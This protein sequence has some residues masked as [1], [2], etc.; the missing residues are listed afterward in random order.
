MTIKY[1]WARIIRNKKGGG[2]LPLLLVTLG[3]I[4]LVLAV[5]SWR[6]TSMLGT[7]Q[8][9]TTATQ[10]AALAAARAMSSI[11]V[12]DPQ[13]G[14]ISLTDSAAK[15][16]GITASDGYA[17]PV[18][19]FNDLLATIRLDMIIADTIGDQSM[20]QFADADYQSLMGAKDRLIQSL[21]AAAYGQQQFDREGQAVDVI[22]EATNAYNAN[23]VRMGGNGATL[24]PGSLKISIGCIPG[25]RTNTQTPLPSTYAF[26]PASAQENNFYRAYINVPYSGK[27]FVFAAIHD[28]IFLVDHS[29]FQL[30]PGLPYF[31]PSIVRAEADEQYMGN[32]TPG[33]EG[34]HVVHVT[35]CAQC[36]TPPEPHNAPG[37]L[38]VSFPDGKLGELGKVADFRTDPILNTTALAIRTTTSG[39][40]Y[41]QGKLGG[42]TVGWA[43]SAAQMWSRVFYDWLR[44][45]GPTVNVKAVVDMQTDAIAPSFASNDLGFINVYT[46]Y[47][48]G[49]SKGWIKKR[50]LETNPRIYGVL[51]DQQICATSL[52]PFLATSRGY[53]FDVTFIDN[54]YRSG[55]ASGGKHGGEPIVDTRMSNAILT[56]SSQNPSILGSLGLPRGRYNSY[57]WDGRFGGSAYYFFK[58][59][60]V[61]PQTSTSKPPGGANAPQPGQ[62]QK[63]AANA[64][65]LRP[66]YASDGMAGE[67]AFHKEKFM[68]PCQIDKFMTT[69]F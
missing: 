41:P 21:Q 65:E 58:L 5:F 68:T 40:D 51:S 62:P 16:K 3:G 27:D 30:D 31:V 24:I 57:T 39:D 45:G 35:A 10:A 53:P 18:R 4:V 55:T 2:I 14:Y 67:I 37:A 42:T 38:F 69:G 59:N 7:H 26:T 20:R 17:L 25:S 19:S 66:T 12:N 64:G 44:R 22:A 13:F 34:K 54:V 43:P 56:S 1:P 32:N 33:S 46:F 60:L 48:T 52:K 50:S 6:F 49:S 63:T 36:G 47:S 15:G 9:Q 8:E 11:V 61:Q 28:S 29:K 23:I